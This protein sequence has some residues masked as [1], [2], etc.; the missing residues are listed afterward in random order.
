MALMRLTMDGTT[1]RVR[2]VYNT[3]VRSFEL[4]EG[5]NAGEMLSDRYERDLRGTKYSYQMAVEP[6]PRYPEDYDAL[7]EAITAP[8]E[9]HSVTVP[10]GQTTLTYDAMIDSGSDTMG[11]YLGGVRAWHGLVIN[12][13]AK[14]IQRA[15]TE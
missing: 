2:I 5:Q 1:Y 4:R 12:F 13:R 8:V 14:N 11:D 9:S 10:Y 6:D 3:L 15:V 7:Y